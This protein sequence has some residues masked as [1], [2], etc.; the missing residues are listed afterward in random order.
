MFKKSFPHFLT[1]GEMRRFNYHLKS[2]NP[3]LSM[4]RNYKDSEAAVIEVTRSE[5]AESINN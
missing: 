4:R 5:D 3:L 2:M 1:K